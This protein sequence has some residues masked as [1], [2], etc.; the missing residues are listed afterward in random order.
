MKILFVCTGNTCRSPIA[1]AIFNKKCQIEGVEAISAGIS[2]VPYSVTSKNSSYIVF[3]NLD[4]DISKRVSVQ[5]TKETINSCDLILTMTQY[6]RNILKNNFSEKAECI[7]TL[8]DFIGAEGDII[9]PYGGDIFLYGETYKELE[10]KIEL[11]LTKLKE[12]MSI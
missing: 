10:K 5:L 9:D 2:V 3:K 6:I 4:I 12:D 11:L 8:S 7:Y 1:E